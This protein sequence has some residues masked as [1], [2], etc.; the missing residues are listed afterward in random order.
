MTTETESQI[1]ASTHPAPQALK[2][3]FDCSV[4][5]V[6]ATVT[7]HVNPNASSTELRL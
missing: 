1:T 2:S 5:T 4:Y 7:A 3:L 6:S